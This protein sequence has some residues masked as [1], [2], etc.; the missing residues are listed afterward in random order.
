MPTASELAAADRSEA[1]VAELIGAD[2]LIYQDLDDL[3]AAVRVENPL[4]TDFDTSCFSGH[5]VTGD[6][7]AKYLH[8]LASARAD[9]AKSNSGSNAAGGLDLHNAN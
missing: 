5:Y 9:E 8:R 7:T 4:L 6:V 2:A 3:I 1:E